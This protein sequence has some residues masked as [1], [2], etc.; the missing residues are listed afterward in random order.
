M[1]FISLED[2]DSIN[3][4]GFEFENY[5]Q[6]HALPIGELLTY[7]DLFTYV[8]DNVYYIE[9][10]EDLSQRETDSETESIY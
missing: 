9:E 6:S 10:E 4:F 2:I 8:A 1:E 5:C 3:T 7:D